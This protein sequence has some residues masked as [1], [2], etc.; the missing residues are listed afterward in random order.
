MIFISVLHKELES[1]GGIL[2]EASFGSVLKFLFRDDMSLFRSGDFL[3][4][5]DVFNFTYGCPE[6]LFLVLIEQM[7]FCELRVER[8]DR[9]VFKEEPD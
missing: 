5:S 3:S 1:V 6:G 7:I 2:V 8:C 9:E 4:S